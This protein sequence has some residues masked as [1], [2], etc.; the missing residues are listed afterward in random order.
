MYSVHPV[1]IGLCFNKLTHPSQ[2]DYRT[3]IWYCI[4]RLPWTNVA[5]MYIVYWYFIVELVVCSKH[6]DRLHWIDTLVLF[7]ST[8]HQVGSN[9]KLHSFKCW[10]IF[11]FSISTVGTRIVNLK[12]LHTRP[13]R[14][15]YFL[16]CNMG[17][18]MVPG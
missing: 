3:F 6:C 5:N 1:T 18:L 9:S 7:C 13:G 14:S 2:S 11:F 4:H 8:L 10:E 12:C 15:C 16:N 17:V